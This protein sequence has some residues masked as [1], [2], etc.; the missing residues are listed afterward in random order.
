MT[1]PSETSNEPVVIV[2][3]DDTSMCVALGNLLRSVGLRVETHNSAQSFLQA[4]LP[5][6][7]T[8]LILDVRMP[9]QSG[10]ELQA[11]LAREDVRIPTI[12]ITGHSDVPMTVKALKAGAIDFLTKPFRNQELLDA[13]NTGLKLACTQHE[14]EK[15]ISGLRASYDAL[16]GR[17]RQIMKLVTD[18][19][20]NKQIAEELAISEITVKIHRG[21][22]MRKM[23][24]KSLPDLVRMAES[25]GL[26]LT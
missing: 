20:M 19:L 22:V 14:E 2:V 4:P 6:S 12:F 3:D 10:L 7:P 1:Q 9:G 25:L 24:A 11:E 13:V 21:N 8:C 5:T 23:D 26:R 15:R 18:G 16:T 17:E